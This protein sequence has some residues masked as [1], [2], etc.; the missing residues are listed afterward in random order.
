M[1]ESIPINT[2]NA[3]IYFFLILLRADKL[4]ALLKMYT[5]MECL[6]IDFIG[7]FADQGYI[8]VRLF[9]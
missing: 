9:E 1:Q 5:P 3:V 2:D 8:V 4:V 6:N 7:P